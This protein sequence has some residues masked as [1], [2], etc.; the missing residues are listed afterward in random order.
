MDLRHLEQIVAIC[1]AGSFP[2]LRGNWAS[3]PDSEQEHHGELEASLGVKLFERT[4]TKAMPTVLWALLSQ[5]NAEALLQNVTSL[6]HMLEQMAGERGLLR[7]G[8]GPATRLRPLPDLVAKLRDSPSWLTRGRAVCRAAAHVTR[9]EGGPV[10]ST[11]CSVKSSS[12][13]TTT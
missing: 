11:P 2:A 13:S 6:G 9:A 4:N 5:T 12:Q 3:Q 10:G 7:I 1:R 8:V